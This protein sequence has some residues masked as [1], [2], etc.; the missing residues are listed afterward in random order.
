MFGVGELKTKEKRVV[1]ANASFWACT[2]AG[3]GVI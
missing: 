2:A 3:F 1:T